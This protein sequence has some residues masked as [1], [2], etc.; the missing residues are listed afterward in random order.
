MKT[1]AI[2]LLQVLITFQKRVWWIFN[3]S[4]QEF[5]ER[6][7]QLL[8]ERAIQPSQGVSISVWCFKYASLLFIGSVIR[9]YYRFL[10]GV[11]P[12]NI[13]Y[14]VCNQNYFQRISPTQNQPAHS[15]LKWTAENIHVKFPHG[16]W[17]PKFTT[18]QQTEFCALICMICTPKRRPSGQISR[19]SIL[20]PH[21]P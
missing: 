7:L 17:T 12:P 6:A 20:S 21:V 10:S 19:W 5:C 4:N 8:W 3:W 15:H 14:F 9:G 18:P 1:P 11:G 13:Y 2:V 16:Q